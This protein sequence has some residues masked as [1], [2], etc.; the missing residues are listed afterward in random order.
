MFMYAASYDMGEHWYFIELVE[1]TDE[2]LKDF[3]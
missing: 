3:R 1:D 2:V